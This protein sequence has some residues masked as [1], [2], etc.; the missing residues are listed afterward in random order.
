MSFIYIAGSRE[1]FP[2]DLGMGGVK[3]VEW[4]PRLVDRTLTACRHYYAYLV[5]DP[6]ADVVLQ[7]CQ[8]R[9]TSIDRSII[10]IS[11]KPSVELRGHFHQVGERI[12]LDFPITLPRCALTVISLM[13]SSRATCLFNNPVTTNAMTSRSRG[14]N[15]AWQSRSSRISA[16]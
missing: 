1:R 3:W 12:G 2:L 9:S 8:A 4:R 7:I 13:P 6:F 15:E 11:E 16:S 14:V 5:S 10:V